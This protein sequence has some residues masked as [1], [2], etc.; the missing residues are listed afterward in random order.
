MDSGRESVFLLFVVAA[1]YFRGWLRLH[2][3]L[4][5][6]YTLDKLMA[7]GSGLAALFVALD[8]PVDAFG[9]LLLRRT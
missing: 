9:A 6:K 3:E 5:R 8:S 1:L 2:G 7:F 4:P